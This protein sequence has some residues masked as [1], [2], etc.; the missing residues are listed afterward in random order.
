MR[1]SKL[2]SMR[3][4]RCEVM[5]LP[6]SFPPPFGVLLCRAELMSLLQEL[7]AAHITHRHSHIQSFANVLLAKGRPKHDHDHVR[8][9]PGVPHFAILGYP[10][11]QYQCHSHISKMIFAEA[12]FS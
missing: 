2:F 7:R 10:W 8:A 3:A 4:S 5:P 6:P 12:S 11:M 1:G 9:H